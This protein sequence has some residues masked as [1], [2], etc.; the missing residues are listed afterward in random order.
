MSIV[1]TVYT[2]H[3][4]LKANLNFAFRSLDWNILS[5]G[6]I[7]SVAY[8]VP[9]S[10][11]ELVALGVLGEVK[12]KEYGERMVKIVISCLENELGLDVDFVKRKRQVKRAKV[13]AKVTSGVAAGA[14]KRTSPYA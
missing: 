4:T 12:L 1:S 13:P 3:N 10:L 11:E 14:Q 6:T 9:T 7:K 8:F 5:V 2:C